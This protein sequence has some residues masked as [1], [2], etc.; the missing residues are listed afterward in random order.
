MEDREV[1]DDRTELE[2]AGC[3]V[4]LVR[5]GLAA[6]YVKDPAEAG[7]LYVYTDA[8]GQPS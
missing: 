1:G 7:P 3:L 6:R 5:G 4:W 8:Q 2:M